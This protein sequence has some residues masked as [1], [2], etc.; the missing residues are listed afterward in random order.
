MEQIGQVIQQHKQLLQ[1]HQQSQ[2]SLQ[3]TNRTEELIKFCKQYSPS[4]QLEICGNPEE[5]FFGDYPTLAR[6][7]AE[8]GK[9]AAMAFIIPQLQNLATY[10]GS[11]EKLDEKQYTECA[12]V[13]S[14]EFHFLKVSEIM[15]FCHRFKAGRYGR[16]YGSVDPLII[17]ES[18]RKF[19]EERCSS[20]DS[21]EKELR[22]QQK[23][24]E[25]EHAISYDEYLRRKS[26]KI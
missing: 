13:I 17:T 15:L 19:C 16:F 5:C 12:F 6:L 23:E 1:Q 4:Y 25:K 10:C 8:Y 24:E 21:H 18:L 11:R 26:V 3:T 7:K 14:T 2:S 20:Y 9:N 22:R